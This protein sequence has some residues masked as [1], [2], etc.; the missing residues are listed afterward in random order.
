MKN[1][2]QFVT[3]LLSESNA[4][5]A[6]HPEAVASEHPYFNIIPQWRA[7]VKPGGSGS[8]EGNCYAENNAVST[9]LEDGKFQ[10]TVTSGGK[11]SLRCYDS[12][13]FITVTGIESVTVDSEETVV[14]WTLPEDVKESESWDLGQKGV[15][16]LEFLN[17]KDTTIANLLETVLLFVP[18]TTQAVD[19]RS[20]SRNVDF[21]D[22]YPHMTMSPRDASS[23]LPPPAEEVHSGDFFGIIRLDGLDPML[24]WG[25]GSTTGHTTIAMWFEDGLYICESTVTDSYWPTNGIQRTPYDTW[26]Q[27]ALDADFNAVHVPLSAEARASFNETA[28]REFFRETEGL[29][30]GFYN[31]LWGWVDTVGDNYPCLPD[32][33]SSEC[34]QWALI[35]TLFAVID[36]RAPAVSD[37]MWNQAWN[38]RIGSSGLGTS[39]IYKAAFDQGID[40]QI[41]PTIPEQDTWMYETTRDGQPA[42]GRSMVCCVFVCHMWK[43][44]GLFGD[45]E[46]NCGEFTNVDDYS[47]A[48]FDSYSQILGDYTL[49]LNEFNSKQMFS[50]MNE[51]CASFAPDYE[52]APDC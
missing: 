28:A 19:A 49:T 20:A 36:R 39:D 13:W 15:R 30:Y 37:L 43:A 35:E 27:Q 12:Y 6:E 22:A 9:P 50:H 1:G 44:G 4:Y 26:L 41:I 7:S 31:M 23:N 32:D 5:I 2:Q 42:V 25:M 52:R 46:V 16:V 29:D 17:D 14:T 3:H 34:L 24:A 18:E 51:Q 45:N 11:K 33:Y 48:I 38:H 40:S 10:I 8:W 21:M 47:L